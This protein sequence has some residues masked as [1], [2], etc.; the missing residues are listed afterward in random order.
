[1]MREKRLRGK[2]E[3]TQVEVVVDE[4]EEEEEGRKIRTR[5]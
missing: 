5:R 3:K 1:M 2:E 4:K